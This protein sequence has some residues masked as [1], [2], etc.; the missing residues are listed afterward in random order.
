VVAESDRVVVVFGNELSG[1]ALEALP[2]LDQALATPNAE[3][4]A[5][6]RRAHLDSL[7]RQVRSTNSTNKPA[8]NENP[9][10]A[11]VPHPTL[12][13]AGE[14]VRSANKF[15]FM[16]LV[17]Y[18]NSLGAVQMGM[19]A[20]SGGLSAAAILGAAGGQIKGLYIAG[21]DPIAKSTRGELNLEEK[22]R[23]LDLLI[24]QD[25]F[26]TETAKLAHVV[27]PSTS[28]AESQGTQVNN[29][30]QVQMVRR[31][32][33]P[34]GQARPD[35]MITNSL[36]RLMGHD[37][38]FQG[39]VKQL[40]KEISEGVPGYEGLSHNR[41]VNEGP[42][43]VVSRAPEPDESERSR[44]LR[45]LREGLKSINRNVA[46]DSSELTTKAGSRLRT[47]YPLMTQ[48]SKMF[49]PDEGA[50]EEKGTPIVFPA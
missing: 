10:T 5:N 42:Q 45:S 46:I 19:A 47:R 39:Q 26:L 29:G 14:P 16:P 36:A 3:V 49:S 27:F 50:G 13:V 41:L 30:G 35:W 11:I 12:E 32:I 4:A 23:G 15:S 1:V 25:L 38:G 33:P 43:Q 20:V 40:F 22:L 31:V 8:V 18:S 48:H 34:V 7:A 28:F 9:L 17:R 6:A 2:L 37:L 21:E 24:V 44:I